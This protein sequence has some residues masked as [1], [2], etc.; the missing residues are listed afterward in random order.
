MLSRLGGVSRNVTECQEI[1]A[2]Y[3]I[4]LSLSVT[5]LTVQFQNRCPPNYASFSFLLQLYSDRVTI[6]DTLQ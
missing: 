6:D 2:I 4:M 1:F 5:Y 3:A